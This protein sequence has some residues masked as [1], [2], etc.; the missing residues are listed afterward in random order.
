MLNFLYCCDENYNLQF[1][2]SIFSLLENVSDE[3]RVYVLHKSGFRKE[4]ISKKIVNHKNLNNIKFIEFTSHVDK[5]PNIKDSHV[6]EATYYRLF[7]DEHI[8]ENLD[9]LIY[10]DADVICIEDPLIQLSEHI[11]RL[12]GNDYIVSVTTEKAITDG[13]KRLGMKSEKY[14]NAGVMIIDYKKWIND[15]I[16]KKLRKKLIENKMSLNFW[17]Q[18]I[19][20]MFFDGGYLELNHELNSR[21]VLDQGE[22]IIN[23]KN[24]DKYFLNK[25]LIHYQG[26]LKPWSLKGI[27]NTK[28]TPYHDYFEIIS[29]GDIHLQYNW[30][31][32]VVKDLINSLLTLNIFSHKKPFRLLIKVIKS[33]LRKNEKY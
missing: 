20:N 33:L 7:I 10:L 3:I 8:N 24:I 15:G 27:L 23:E 13:Q 11:E 21:A 19:L 2:T 14:F 17:D 18:D 28:A 25:K 4:Y 30:K 5:F 31:G 9:I 1:Q 32:N 16:G 29:N 12:I 26:K 6:S 22:K